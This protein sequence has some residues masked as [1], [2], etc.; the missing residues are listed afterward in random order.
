MDL[1]QRVER[2]SDSGS[3]IA[4]DLDILGSDLRCRSR[5]FLGAPRSTD[6]DTG[7]SVLLNNLEPGRLR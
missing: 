3:E 7:A 5:T 2:C 1:L 6:T 4:M